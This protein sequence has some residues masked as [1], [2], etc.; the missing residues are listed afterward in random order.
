M[1]NFNKNEILETVRMISDQNLD[2]RTITMA[3]SLFDCVGRTADETAELVYKK[4]ISQ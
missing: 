4:I 3:L 1:I 2:V